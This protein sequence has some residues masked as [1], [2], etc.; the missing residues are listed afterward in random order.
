ML[1]LLGLSRLGDDTAQAVRWLALTGAVAAAVVS[2][3]RVPV[4]AS[5]LMGGTVSGAMEP[6][7]LAM[8]AESPLGTSLWVR[9]AGCGLI[10]FLVV[11]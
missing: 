10:C 11:N 6:A 4:R 8:V 7:I 9:L 2:A 5:F 1:A 3:L